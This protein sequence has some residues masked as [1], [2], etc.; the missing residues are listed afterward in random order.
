MIEYQN[1]LQYIEYLETTLFVT[2]SFIQINFVVQ[3]LEPDKK[4]DLKRIQMQYCAYTCISIIFHICM[5]RNISN[6]V[7]NN[8]IKLASHIGI[9]KGIIL[10]SP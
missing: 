9:S 4:I 5:Y 6:Y 1:V 8:S 10:S 7:H 3:V 2:S